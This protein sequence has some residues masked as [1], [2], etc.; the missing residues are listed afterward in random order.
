MSWWE[1]VKAV[2]QRE[3][4]DISEGLGKVG[5]SLDAE[6]ARKERELAAGPTERIDMLLEEQADED[7]RFQELEERLR[8]ATSPA[9]GEAEIGEAEPDPP[10]PT[11]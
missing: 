1:R 8:G 5:K 7:A 11:A 4:A 2:F 6:L 10:G 3:A 9:R